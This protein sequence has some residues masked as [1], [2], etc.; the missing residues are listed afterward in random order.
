MYLCDTHTHT[1]ISPDSKVE[2]ADTA[3]AA[4]AAGL[5]AFCVTDHS[6]LLALDG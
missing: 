5:R 4:I 1:K 2:L 3:R 6:D